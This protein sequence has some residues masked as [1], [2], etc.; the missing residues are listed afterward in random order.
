MKKVLLGALFVLGLIAGCDGNKGAG[1]GKPIVSKDVKSTNQ[2]GKL[3]AD[4]LP[5]PP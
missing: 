4:E 2:K 3:V 5:P 1:T